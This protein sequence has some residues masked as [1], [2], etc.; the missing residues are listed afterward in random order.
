MG[1]FAGWMLVL[2]VAGCG[3][4]HAGG[5]KH[6]DKLARWEA[7]ENLLPGVLIEVQPEG[8]GWDSC[9]I[10]AVSDE[11]LTCTSESTQSRMVYPRS[12]VRNVWVIEP[13]G[14]EHVG[15]WIAIG[16]GF[17]VG[18]V[19]CVP[20]GPAAFFVCGGLGAVIVAGAVMEP[21]WNSGWGYPGPA[22]VPPRRWHRRL[23]Y[24][25]AAAPAD[26]AVD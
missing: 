10:A 2:L 9:R 5:K 25:A 11:E 7:V 22:G 6:A 1:K 12:V 18:G 15:R 14:D 23:V 8:Q 4:A 13:R 24:R 17:V 16:V 26:T 20:G 21:R 3:V 19:L